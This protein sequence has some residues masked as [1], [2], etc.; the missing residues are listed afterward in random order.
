MQ[1]LNLRLRVRHDLLQIDIRVSALDHQGSM[2]WDSLGRWGYP[3]G[4]D[5]GMRNGEFCQYNYADSHGAG[6]KRLLIDV[7]D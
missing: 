2:I 7:C 1:S 6:F 3:R 5:E 4:E